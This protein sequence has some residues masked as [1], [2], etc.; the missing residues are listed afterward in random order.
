MSAKIGTKVHG[1][2]TIDPNPRI[3]REALR[4]AL[5]GFGNAPWCNPEAINEAIEL[6]ISM[7]PQN[8][9]MCRSCQEVSIL[10][11]A[12]CENAECLGGVNL[13]TEPAEAV[14]PS[15]EEILNVKLCGEYLR[16]GKKMPE[17]RAIHTI[18]ILY[19]NYRGE[20]ARRKIIPATLYFGKTEFH[21]EF[22]WLLTAFDVDKSATR[23]F[24]MRDIHEWNPTT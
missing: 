3:N 10:H 11:C 5:I 7:T 19:T 8:A 2:N 17:L 13:P 14:Q 24:A 16:A 12:G 22:Q 20:T 21:P 18:E 15:A 6:L 1:N 4:S 9:P 23:T